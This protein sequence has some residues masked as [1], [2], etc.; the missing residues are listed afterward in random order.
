MRLKFISWL[1]VLVSAGPAG[2]GAGPAEVMTR[3]SP[4]PKDEE[5]TAVSYCR[6]VGDQAGYAGKPVRVKAVVLVWLDGSSLY[7]PACPREGLEPVLDCADAEAC[8]AM[9]KSLEQETDFNGDVG[10]VEAVL[11]G[12]LEVPPKTPAGKS[13]AKFRIKTI[14]RVTRIPPDVPWPDEQR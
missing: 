12:R 4:S 11:I 2:A 13:R 7:D 14:E 1:L 6:L 9:R 5:A 8:A 10:R 3:Q